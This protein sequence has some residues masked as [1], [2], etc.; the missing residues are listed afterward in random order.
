M[1]Y[2]LS[3]YIVGIQL[4]NWHSFSYDLMLR[5]CTLYLSSS[6]LIIQYRLGP[7]R[8]QEKTKAMTQ[9]SETRETKTF[10][11]KVRSREL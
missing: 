4:N 10:G 1:I 9:M 3:V 5:N 6:P 7:L 11:K 8:R 2:L